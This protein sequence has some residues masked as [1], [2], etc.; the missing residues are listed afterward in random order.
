MGTSISY[1]AAYSNIHRD[2]SYIKQS[3]KE[4]IS[5]IDSVSISNRLI[6]QG[7]DV[8]ITPFELEA[9]RGMR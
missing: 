8:R 1:T 5:N 7:F 9:K 2:V 4:P 3:F 6:S